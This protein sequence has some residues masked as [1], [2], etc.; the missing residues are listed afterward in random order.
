MMEEF[1]DEGLQGQGT[2]SYKP[3]E[4][5]SHVVVAVDGKDRGVGGVQGDGH[6]QYNALEEIAGSVAHPALFSSLAL[7]IIAEEV[8]HKLDVFERDEVDRGDEV[9]QS[10]AADRKLGLEALGLDGFDGDAGCVFE[11]EQRDPHKD[12][13]LHFTSREVLQVVELRSTVEQSVDNPSII[14]DDSI[15]LSALDIDE[16]ASDEVFLAER[17]I[18]EDEHVDAGHRVVFAVGG[19][20]D[21]HLQCLEPSRVQRSVLRG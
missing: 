6:I 10:N 16:V 15:I 9:A 19:E 14:S 5:A 2:D 13:S 1:S 12:P 21:L 20:R 8:E 3:L 4:N 11:G 18:V 17:V 7:P